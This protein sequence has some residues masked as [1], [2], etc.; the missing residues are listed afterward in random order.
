MTTNTGNTRTV[1]VAGITLDALRHADGT[2]TIAL[3]QNHELFRFLTCSD[4]REVKDL[5]DGDFRFLTIQYELGMEAV[6]VIDIPIFIK[7]I[8][9]LNGAGN[10]KVHVFTREMFSVSF[11][12]LFDA[13]FY[14]EDDDTEYRKQIR[15]CLGLPNNIPV[16]RY[17]PDQIRLMNHGEGHYDRL[18]RR[19]LDHYDALKILDELY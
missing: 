5:L 4:S 6:H 10:K 13:A 9:A 19:G 3:P 15:A 14:E 17:T 7:L 11:T 16:N 1:E 2:Y 12:E 8:K 18:R